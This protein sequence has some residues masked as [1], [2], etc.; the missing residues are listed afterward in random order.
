MPTGTTEQLINDLRAI[1][2]RNG[3]PS[4]SELARRTGYP[5]STLHDALKGGRLP[6]CDLVVA[7]AEA[8]GEPGPVWKERWIAASAEVE[9]PR[10]E[11][12]GEPSGRP[13]GSH[14]ARPGEPRP[15]PRATSTSRPGTPGGQHPAPRATSTSHPHAPGDRRPTPG[16]RHPAVEAIPAELPGEPHSARPAVS[17]RRPEPSGGSPTASA[18]PAP[19]HGEPAGRRGAWL[20]A[21]R[22]SVVTAVVAGAV[23]GLVGAAVAVLSARGEPC[24]PA[25]EYR[26][27]RAG[28]VLDAVGSPVGEVRVADVVQVRTM[29]HDRYPHR[30]FGTVARTGVSGY[31]DEAKLAFTAPVC[32]A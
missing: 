18:E 15:T 17:G 8:C 26:V 21:R 4:F 24:A 16:E 9:G 5:R 31:V 14:P 30:Y 20:R 28:A 19:G 11:T 22:V 6:A 3:M 12:P 25:R 13:F 10:G 1:R 29:A 7:L 2:R 27:T 32:T 23:A